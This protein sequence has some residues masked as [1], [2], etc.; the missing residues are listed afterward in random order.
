[1]LPTL[2]ESPDKLSESP[3]KSTQEATDQEGKSEM[4]KDFLFVRE[5]KE[6]WCY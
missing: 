1:M 6:K 5:K 4:V 2:S 3:D